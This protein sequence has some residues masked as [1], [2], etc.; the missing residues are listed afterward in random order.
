MYPETHGLEAQL[1]FLRHQVEE[2]QQSDHTGTRCL[3]LESDFGFRG[4]G[5]DNS[6]AI[7]K[8]SA[9]ALSQ[10]GDGRASDDHA[11]RIAVR[12]RPGDFVWPSGTVANLYG[13]EFLGANRKTCTFRS[14]DPSG[15]VRVG[16]FERLSNLTIENFQRASDVSPLGREVVWNN[17]SFKYQSDM[18]GVYLAN[19][20]AENVTVSRCSVQS[21][22]GYVGLW[23][24]GARNA[25]IFDCQ[26]T[27]DLSHCIRVDGILP[28]G[29]VRVVGNHTKGGSTGIFFP[30][31]RS[32]CVDSV[33]IEGNTVE[34]FREEGISLDG[35]GNNVS[36]FSV[37]GDGTILSA[38]NDA[39][40]RLVIT[41]SLIFRSAGGTNDPLPVSA[42]SDWTNY[43]ATF[44]HGSG[45]PGSYA[46]V[47]SSDPELGTLTLDTFTDSDLV[48]P[49]GNFGVHTGFWG[50]VVRGNTLHS[51]AAY[52]GTDYTYPTGISF[53]LD[54]YDCVA[55]Y[56]R[57]IGCANGITVAGGLL[58]GSVE[59]NAWGTQLVGN[60][61][62]RC[63]QIPTV[64]NG[65]R[66]AIRI[67]QFY[68]GTNK[69]QYRNRCRNNVLDGG[70]AYVSGQDDASKVWDASN[71]MVN[72]ASFQSL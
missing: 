5:S 44:A 54:A 37:I 8:L 32:Y 16:G 39:S 49:G 21:G 17:C 34:D 48:V 59:A 51:M 10:R 65:Y 1:F 25:S 15:L 30:S 41:P 52:G 28:G 38:S 3:D 27:G 50:C 36:M 20:S 69:V 24:T 60:K 57:I 53:W 70:V 4:D 64:T 42:I 13:I 12:V 68:G 66:G 29:R 26:A 22:A 67:E 63:H 45:I 23:I 46:R 55:E 71:E 7:N 11:G 47:Y 19:A 72:G 9:F 40:G 56:N 62:I 43:M 18:P 33:L 6:I 58:Y 31:N 14:S 2:L 35:M 61:L